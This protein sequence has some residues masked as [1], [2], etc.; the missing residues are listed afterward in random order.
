MLVAGDRPGVRQIVI[1]GETGFLAPEGDATALAD[2][3]GR[4][5]DD[6]DLIA[7]MRETALKIIDDKHN[8]MSAAKTL[9]RIL[10]EA[11]AA[12]RKPV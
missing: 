9:D 3:M 5:M 8:L 7:E 10:R 2:A 11:A 1:D 4:L 6:P 12:S